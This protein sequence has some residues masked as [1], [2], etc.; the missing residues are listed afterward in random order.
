MVS[1][2]HHGGNSP[3]S[4]EGTTRETA[5]AE[6]AA[7]SINMLE[8]RAILTDNVID[9]VIDHRDRFVLRGRASD[10]L[11]HGVRCCADGPHAPTHVT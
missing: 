9:Q 3:S 10:R 5:P 7:R 8:V 2:S 4:A 6:V 1:R 11:I